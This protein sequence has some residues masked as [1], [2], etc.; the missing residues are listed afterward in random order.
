MTR[1]LTVPGIAYGGDYHRRAAGIPAV[2]R[3]RSGS[4][5]A[6]YL[7]THPDPTTMAAVLQQICRE[8]NV[9]SER[10]APPGVEVA[11]R[12]GPHADYLFLI[13]H[14]EA[15]AEIAANGVELLTGKP[16]HGSPLSL[17]TRHTNHRRQQPGP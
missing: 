3:R 17:E 5:A 10:Q 12:R 11:L 13:D 15:G 2:T 7:A 14:A 16:V 8:A 9:A 4:G 6:W 1:S